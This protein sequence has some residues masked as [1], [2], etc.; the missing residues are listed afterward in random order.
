MKKKKF[1]CCWDLE[2]PISVIDFAAKLSRN[3][4]EVLGINLRKYNMEDF[5]TMLS[6]YDDYIV[7]VPGIKEKFNILEYQPG[8]TLRLIV[9]LYILAFTDKDLLNLA[10]NNLG[11]L[12]GCKELMTIL[13]REWDV[14]VIST[15][16][17]HFALTVSDKLNIPKDHVY[18]TD[19]NIS[20]LK[21]EV[22]DIEQEVNILIKEIFDKYLKNNK[23]LDYVIEDLDNFFWRTQNS[24]YIKI[25]N[26]IKVRGGK[27]KELA[28]EEISRLTDFPISE[29]IAV[30]DSITDINMLQRVKDEGGIALSFN[31]NRFSCE[32]ANVAINTPNS[33]GVLPIFRAK[34]K[35]ADFLDQWEL[36][37]DSFDYNPEN[38]PNNIISKECRNFFIKYNFVPEIINLQNKSSE[39]MKDIISRQVKMRKYMRSQL[40]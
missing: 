13:L 23:N 39:E 22:L 33:L 9:P 31:G 30:G 35:I 17:N 1:C 2:G 34:P 38:I 20:D 37:F 26:Q 19:L 5:F 24:N 25:M 12:P 28:V 18:S 11:L 15:S 10:R 16:Y 32:R 27:R 8:D 7:D 29:M 40:N 4:N 14:F 6:D 21:D 3:L 36:K